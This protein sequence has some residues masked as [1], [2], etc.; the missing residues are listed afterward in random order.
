MDFDLQSDFRLAA[1][2][3]ARSIDSRKA[4]RPVSLLGCQWNCAGV[5]GIRARI[6]CGDDKRG[7]CPVPCLLAN[8]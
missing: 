5:A 4:E 6:D 1:F 7:F 2:F 3:S 8:R